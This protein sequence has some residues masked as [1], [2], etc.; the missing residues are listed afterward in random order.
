MKDYKVMIKATFSND[1]HRRISQLGKTNRPN[2]AHLMYRYKNLSDKD[3]LALLEDMMK[4]YSKS[5][6]ILKSAMYKR[7]MKNRTARLR[8]QKLE[9]NQAA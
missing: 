1:I 6:E 3:K 9:K 8:K 7:R 5:S 4:I 2:T